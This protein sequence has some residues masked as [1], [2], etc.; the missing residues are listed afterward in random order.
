MTEPQ[1]DEHPKPMI[2]ISYSHKDE[3]W[4]DRLETQLKVLQVHG[5]L[6]IWDD[7]RIQA[8]GD[9]RAEIETALAKARA[10]VLM[11]SADF[12]TSEFILKNEIPTLLERREKEGL[13]IFPLI[14]KS[15]PWKKIAW[16]ARLN[17]RPR[18]GRPL[19]AG[20]EAQI[21]ADLAAFAEEIHDLL[22]PSM[23]LGRGL[24]TCSLPPDHVFLSKLPSTGPD[25]FGRENELKILDGAWKDPA[26][27][28][29]S[30]VAFGG[31][32]KSTLINHWL[33]RMDKA[34]FLGAA[35]VYGWS[36]YSQGTSEDRQVSADSFLAHALEWFGDPDPNKGDPFAK[37]ARLATLIKKERTL[38]ILDGL[39]PLQYPPG[40]MHGSLKDQGIRALLRELGRT[41]FGLCL[42]STRVA[43]RDLEDAAP[44]SVKELP[45]EN[46][47]AEAGARLLSKLGVEGSPDRLLETV[48]KFGGHALAL[49][50][51]GRYLAL[52]HNGDIRRQDEIPALFAEEKHGGHARRVMRSYEKWLSAEPE[53]GIL[54]IL[55]LFDRPATMAAIKALF[56]D[57]PIDGLTADLP[58]P[59]SHKWSFAINNLR[60]LG[61]LAP[62][63]TC[64]GEADMLDCHPLVREHFAD[65]LETAHS[66]SKKEAHSRLYAY[67]KALP[68]KEF[69]DTLEEMEPLFMAVAH[70]CR[71][72]RYQETLEDVYWER[73][74]RKEKAYTVHKLGAFDADLVVL[75][76][77]F[78]TPWI[79]PVDGLTDFWKGGVLSWAGFRLWALGRLQEAVQPMQAGLEAQINQ[80]AWKNAA[81]AASNLSELHL[82]LGQVKKALEYGRQ[83]VAYADQ[84]GEAFWKMAFRTTLAHALHQAGRLAQARDLFEE[85]EAMQRKR[86]PQYPYLYS[87][88]GFRFCD[89][90]LSQGAYEEV[91]QR[92]GQ[93]LEWTL[94]EGP[95]LLDI[96]LDTLSLGRASLLKAL[97]DQTP[98]FTPA[99]SFL[100]QAVEKLRKAGTQNHLPRGL[101]A[102]AALFRAQDRFD[103]AQTDLSEAHDI[104]EQGGME[105][106]LADIH[107]EFCRLCLAQNQTQKALTELA[108]AK[109]MIQRTGY[110]RRDGE[111]VELSRQLGGG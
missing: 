74:K 15:C 77:F 34:H 102:R 69:P 95:L 94:Q 17:V 83:S 25:L 64:R 66:G 96:A 62:K 28:I 110:H 89:L 46:L 107:L 1:S 56:A 98:D 10:A 40:D 2:F 23:P 105:L 26:M 103:Q 14:L 84:R 93:T 109:E 20:S 31:V 7:R 18:D 90:L 4:K 11:V 12:L 57:A 22:I 53:L 50:L 47:S 54:K 41:H 43:L 73:I 78:D 99:E 51:L 76:G 75:S 86:Q 85:A 48:Q 97:A 55:G 63:E 81:S 59:D 100:N 68:E 101:L 104:A 9:W 30:L 106:F 5:N 87:M 92:A 21:N 16:L 71:A 52:A 27:R 65:L 67:Y 33:N 37:G 38:L 19:E 3:I 6:D 70:G 24:Q 79:R 80:K 39:E 61:L 13:K 8:G 36:F 32:G 82:T 35:R 72:G 58:H 91:G 44:E 42:I 45:L 49:N 60:T 88:G 29:L 108:S 111:L